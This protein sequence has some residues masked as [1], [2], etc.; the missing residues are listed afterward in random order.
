MSDVHHD[1][2]I[3]IGA[4]LAG[5]AAA[6]HLQ[7]QGI[8]V[9]VI[10]AQEHVGGRVHSMRQHGSNKEAGGTYIGAGYKS[11]VGAAK[12][13]GIELIDVTP[14]LE[15]FREQ[16]LVLN[17]KI[18]RQAEWPVHPA[19]PFPKMDKSYMPW[20]YS[21]ILTVRENPLKE[22]KDWLNP[23]QS[24]NDISLF[25]WMKKLGLS[26]EAINLAYGI[27]V[28]FGNNAHDVSAL[29]MLFRAAF[30]SHQRR[31]AKEGIIG[32]TALN[33]VQQI[34]IAMANALYKEPHLGKVVKSIDD[35]GSLEIRCADGATYRAPHVICSIPLGALRD[36]AIKPP[37]SKLQ[38]KAIIDIPS[39]PTTQIFLAH[40]SKF[41]ESD[42]LKPSMYTNG[43]AGMIAAARNGED[44]N[45]VTS[46]TAWTMGSNAQIL[47]KLPVD[48]AGKLIIQ[49]IEKIRPSAQG[50]LEFLGLKSWGADPFARGGWAYFRPG[51]VTQLYKAIGKP[52]GNLHFC[53]EHLS[54]ANRGMEGAMES[55]KQAATQILNK[56][57][58]KQMNLD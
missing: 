54:I 12:D 37:L 23:S 35:D 22:P 34:P 9:Q 51:Q 45:E 49:E 16:E 36:V 38:H 44:P 2:V 3:V 58:T 13:Y 21:R 26:E 20:N 55:G 40:K 6:L 11:V 28:S 5:L 8:S 41:W 50:Q 56:D 19:N 42:G 18:I 10:E 53:G 1:E 33:G 25:S 29:L 24:H 46:F 31:Y 7:N 47:D 14:T 27:N 32:Y 17:E 15:F 43:V 57:I 30:S 52:H 48:E 4:G 39:Q